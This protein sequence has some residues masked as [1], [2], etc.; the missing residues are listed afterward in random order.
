MNAT[1]PDPKVPPSEL[2]DLLRY[3]E[4]RVA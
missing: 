1:S 3:G 4:T 2:G